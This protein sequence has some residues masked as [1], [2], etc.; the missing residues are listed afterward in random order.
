MTQGCFPWGEGVGGFYSQVKMKFDFEKEALIA[1]G[2]KDDDQ[3]SVYQG[4]LCFLHEQFVS[5]TALSNDLLIKAGQLFQWLWEVK[6]RR[7]ES[8]GSYKLTEV[9]DAQMSEESIAIGNCLGLTL[10]YHC[11]LR[12]TGLEPEA[13]YL[14]NAFGIGPHVLSLL[15][16]KHSIIDIE[17]IFAEGF[18]YKGHLNAPMRTVWGDREL[19]AD[20]YHSRGN[21]SFEKED[22]SGALENYK[23]AV[24][25]N[26][27]YQRAHFNI[28]ILLDRMKME[29]T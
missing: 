23:R 9:V 29:V 3:T 5:Q 14:E 4:R 12:R 25:L 1:S 15:R 7:Y 24:N 11:L 17:N 26:P 20:I 2:T 13:L 16:T 6:P 22:F 21:E 28:T 8:H 10:L 19:V 18:D 27:K